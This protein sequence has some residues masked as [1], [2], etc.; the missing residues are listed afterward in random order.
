M[1]RPVALLPG[2]SGQIG[3]FAIPLLV[4]AG[5][6]V[7]ALSRHGKPH[8]YPEFDD[9]EWLAPGSL[10]KAQS[11]SVR[12]LLSCGP[13]GLASTLLEH[14]TEARR[15]VV[16]STSSIYTK[17]NSENQRERQQMELIL[18]EEAGLKRYC[19]DRGKALTLFRPTLV[20]GCGLDRNISLLARW[21]DRFG[22]LPIAGE[23]RGLRQ[24]VHCQDLAAAA[25]AAV[26]RDTPLEIESPLCG[27]STLSFHDMA[28]RIFNA[29]GG[30]PR[31]VSMPRG[32]LA[33]LVSAGRIFPGF[34]G[35]NPE[36]VR[37]QEQDLVFDDRSLRKTLDFETRPFRPSREDFEMPAGQKFRTL[38]QPGRNV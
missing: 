11:A 4:A 22:F 26:K 6:R 9:V 37:R 32:L 29:L 10:T 38:A 15:V 5:I 19:S 31:L 18:A 28:V 27:G 2:A 3:V 30:K 36:M 17:L 16:F 13:L 21:I 14:C 33:L 25:V 34:R 35:A 7:L 1:S 23:A 20:Y 24:P 8:A 12:Y